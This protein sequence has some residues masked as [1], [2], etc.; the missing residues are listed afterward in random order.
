[1][2]YKRNSPFRYTF[3][4]PI[5]AY[6]KIV[7]I[8]EESVHSSKGLAKIMNISPS[9][10]KLN[11]AL[12]IPETDHKSI[13]LSLRFNVNEEEFTF[14]GEIVWKKEM[15]ITND[16]GIKLLVEE[17]EEQVLIEQLKLHSKN[18]TDSDQ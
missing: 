11:S 14:I 1:M 3:E 7:K 2:K 9:G 15:A 6:F 17:D 16:Y 5:P 12:N 10:V 4:E 13:K 18:A 8:N